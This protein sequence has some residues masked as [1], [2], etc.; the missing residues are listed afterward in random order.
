MTFT[1]CEQAFHHRKTIPARGT[2]ERDRRANRFRSHGGKIA[3]RST[4]SFTTDERGLISRAEMTALDDGVGAQAGTPARRP[5][6]AIVADAKNAI[7]IADTFPEF[8]DQ[9]VFTHG[10][11]PDTAFRRASEQPIRGGA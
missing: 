10:Y 4:R 7:R 5:D 3:E 6:A 9:V 2:G 1:F 8:P 11:G